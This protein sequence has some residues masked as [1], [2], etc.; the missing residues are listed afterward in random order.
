MKAEYAELVLL[1]QSLACAEGM[2]RPFSDRV[3]DVAE[4]TGGSILFDIRVDGDIQIQRFA[5]IGWGGGGTVVIL[6][7]KDGQLGIASIDED[8]NHL[9]AELTAWNSLPMPE[10]V[11][12]SYSG[13]AASLL[14]KLR[15]SGRWRDAR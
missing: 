14:A 3:G 1:E 8:N 7:G 11:G 2:G 5:A 4:K 12:V 10:Q 6:M 13:A 15:K 9:V